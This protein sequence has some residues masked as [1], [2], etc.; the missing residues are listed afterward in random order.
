MPKYFRKPIKKWREGLMCIHP[1]HTTRT[2]GRPVAITK[3][4]FEKKK[5]GTRNKGRPCM[6]LYEEN[7]N[8]HRKRAKRG[9]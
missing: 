4:L 6:W 5:C 7:A 8:E 9:A 1:Y 2:R 3:E